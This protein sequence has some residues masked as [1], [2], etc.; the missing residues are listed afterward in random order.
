[1]AHCSTICSI[2]PSR[3]LY[4]FDRTRNTSST[5]A[6]DVPN[7][8][9]SI[10]CRNTRTDLERRRLQVMS[11]KILNPVTQYAATND[12]PQKNDLLN[13]YALHWNIDFV[14]S[15]RNKSVSV[16]HTAKIEMVASVSEISTQEITV[17]RIKPVLPRSQHSQ[18]SSS[19][20][21]TRDSEIILNKMNSKP[22]ARKRD[23]QDQSIRLEYMDTA[24]RGISN[25]IE[26]TKKGKQNDE[27]TKQI[28]LPDR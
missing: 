19:A 13:S 4:T 2:E 6:K 12:P 1:M 5:F 9:S 25:I 23:D 18:L 20:G 3:L 14:S 17:T 27:H 21:Y 16:S 10:S 22:L 28:Y 15:P 8:Y 11:V 26:S 24:N 7:E